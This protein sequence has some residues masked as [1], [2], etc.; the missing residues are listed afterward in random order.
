MPIDI[1]TDT[2]LNLWRYNHPSP[3]T[4]QLSS[5]VDRADS[6][7]QGA[8]PAGDALPPI[9]Q[10]AQSLGLSAGTV[11]SAYRVL[12]ARGLTSSDRRRGTWVRE[13]RKGDLAPVRQAMPVPEGVIDC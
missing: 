2:I 1:C 5:L 9:R 13:L 8:I 6:I 12:N 4:P 10:L 7:H 3:A 11:A